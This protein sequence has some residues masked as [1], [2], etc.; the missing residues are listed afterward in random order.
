VGDG[1][2]MCRSHWENDRIG[3]RPD[4]GRVLHGH[5]SNKGSATMVA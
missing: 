2:L 1:C 4:A 5:L 3:R